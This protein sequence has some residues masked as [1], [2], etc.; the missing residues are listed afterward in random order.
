MASIFSGRGAVAG[1]LGRVFSLGC[2][3][4]VGGITIKL[5]QIEGCDTKVGANC[6]AKQQV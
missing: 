3:I 4:K 1:Q 6:V 2:D 5:A